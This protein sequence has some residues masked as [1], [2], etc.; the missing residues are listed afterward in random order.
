MFRKGQTFQRQRGNKPDEQRLAWQKSDKALADST[1][2]K[3]QELEEL[4]AKKIRIM[5]PLGTSF[6]N[7]QAEYKYTKLTPHLHP[8]ELVKIGD[9]YFLIMSKMPGVNLGELIDL[10]NQGKIKINPDLLLK[11]SLAMVD[12]LQ[13]QIFDVDLLHCDIKPAQMMLDLND[14][15]HPIVRLIDLGSAK[16]KSDPNDLGGKCTSGYEIPGEPR[17]EKSDLFGLGV[18]LIKLLS[19]GITNA[20]FKDPSAF[21]IGDR[22]CKLELRNGLEAVN[23]NLLKLLQSMVEKNPASRPN[24]TLILY[25]LHDL[26]REITHQARGTTATEAEDQAAQKAFFLHQMP[27][28]KRPKTLQEIKSGIENPSILEGN[29]NNSAAV[30]EYI[31]MSGERVLRGCASKDDILSRLKELET[32]HYAMEDFLKTKL[33]ALTAGAKQLPTDAEAIENYKSYL[34]RK[35]DKYLN[36]KFSS[37]D[38]HVYAMS[39]MSAALNKYKNIYEIRIGHLGKQVT[40][41]L[42]H[43]A[44]EDTY[45]R[46]MHEVLLALQDHSSEPKKDDALAQL[47]YQIKI[48]MLN[49]VLETT[50]EK[51]IQ[52]GKRSMSSRRIGNMKAILHLVNNATDAGVLIKALNNQLAAF[53]TGVFFQS[54]LRNTV[55]TAIEQWEKT[56]RLDVKLRK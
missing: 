31:A 16:L 39:A 56:V 53:E 5:K 46:Q 14:P 36:K 33:D 7:A 22:K 12:A 50:S 54:A 4:G 18:S 21:H 29:E 26:R 24:P 10:M 45:V 42:T 55:N 2:G 37:V 1:E 23:T 52:E 6:E 35:A 3:I 30:E 13:K 25:S 40:E 17:T 47:A 38:E 44:K 32:Q 43:H 11:I 34:E 15:D 20:S 19:T 8:K 9:E 28:F 49:Y 41:K 27:L 48:N 51:S